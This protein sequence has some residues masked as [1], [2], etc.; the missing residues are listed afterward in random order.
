MLFSAPVLVFALGGSLA[1]GQH[2]AA[3]AIDG[4]YRGTIGKQAIVLEIGA[5]DPHRHDAFTDEDVPNHA[6]EGRYFYRQHGV[7]ILVEGTVL[8]DGSL[9]LQEYQHRK[10][11]GAEWRLWFHQDSANGFFCRCDAR[12]S[13]PPAPHDGL[14][15]SLT[16]VSHGFDPGLGSLGLADNPTPDQAYY[17]LLLDFPLQTGPE[18]PAGEWGA[19]VMQTDERFKVVLPHLTRF[20]DKQ[21]MSR[22]N[23]DL[24]ARLKG[25][26]LAAADCLQGLDFNSGS[27]DEEVHVGVFTERILSIVRDEEYFCGGAHPDGG[28][29]PI[30]YDMRTGRDLD[31]KDVFK[32]QETSA[33]LEYGSVPQGATHSLL[34]GLYKKHYVRPDSECD[35]NE[36]GD[37]TAIKM[38]FDQ[39]GLVIAPE[40][41]HATRGC[42]PAITIPYPELR[43]FLREEIRF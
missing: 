10:P 25:G 7:G 8:K 20:P 28:P 36:I 3:G 13:R 41:S 39:T 42:G 43:P 5:T 11:S 6:I 26:R 29:D 4:V 33:T 23:Q 15:I 17:D 19:Y 30:L 24:A 38:Y 35:E 16:R 18:I 22:V 40:L 2:M 14:S 12:Q 34:L 32:V 9:R 31:M 1:W 21:V 27:W 37:D